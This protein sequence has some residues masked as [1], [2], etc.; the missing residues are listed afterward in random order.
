MRKQQKETIIENNRFIFFL[1][2]QQ[3][4]NGEMRAQTNHRDKN[5]ANANSDKPQRGER[6]YTKITHTHTHSTKKK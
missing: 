3:A 5:I 4:T 1:Q 2:Q 6:E